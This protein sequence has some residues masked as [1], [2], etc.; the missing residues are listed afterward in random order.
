MNITEIKT[1]LNYLFDN[2]NRLVEKGLDKIAVNIVGAAGI[3][4]TMCIKQLAEDRGCGYTRIN[5]SEIEEV[6]D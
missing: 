2:N 6:G 5:L 3:G 4:K 1:T